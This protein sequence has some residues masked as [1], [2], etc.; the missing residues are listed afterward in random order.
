M[1]ERQTQSEIDAVAHFVEAVRELRTS[2]FFMEEYRSLSIS[3]REGDPKEKIQGKFPDPSILRGMLVPFR[4]VWHENEPCHYAKVTKILKRYVPESR[5][6]L[7]SLAFDA[8]RSAVGQLPLFR[9]QPLSVSDVINI[10]LNTR[11]HHVGKSSHCGR[12]TRNDFDRFNHSIG[13]VLFEFYFLSAIQE[14]GIAFFNIQQCAESFLRGFAEQGLTPS[15]N[16]DPGASEDNVQ[17]ATPGY[18]PEQNTPKQRVWRL[19]R[20]RHYEG[21]NYFLGLLDCSDETVADLI[22][23]CDSF[24][25]F[26]KCHGATL[27]HTDNFSAIDPEDCTHFGGCIDNY[28]T[29][30]RNRRPRK[31]FVA[32]R[33]DGTLIWGEDYVSVLRD[34]YVEFRDAFLRE[35]F[36]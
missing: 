13:P 36:R 16:L 22:R 8:T 32:R 35:P 5:W 10:W 14:A 29:V 6:F 27:T 1:S 23:R 30:V 17:R 31:G 20:R 33:R 12:F 28:P 4:R 7:D 9:D 2:P 3:M 18:T 21:F 34:Q 25:Q 24:D 15:F 26:A 11:Y 19:R